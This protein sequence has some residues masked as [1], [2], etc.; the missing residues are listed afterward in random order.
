MFLSKT[1]NS[2]SSLNMLYT[3]ESAQFYSAFSPITFSVT[4]HFCQKCKVS[5]CVFTENA[6]YNLKT[7][8]FEDNA[9]FHFVFL[10]TALSFASR[11]RR[12]Q[13]R[14]VSS[15]MLKQGLSIVTTF[16]PP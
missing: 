9:K 12:K 14:N 1:L 15:S 16:Y 4:Q 7:C 3:A 13:D 10:A 8:S 6:Q 11:F 5:L 2:A